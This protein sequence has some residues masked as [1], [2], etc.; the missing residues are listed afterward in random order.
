MPTSF[1]KYTETSIKAFDFNPKSQE[2][3][4]RKQ[5]IVKSIAEHYKNTP[6]SILFYGFSPL[7]MG[8]NCKNISVTAITPTIKNY[9]DTKGI[10]YTYIADDDL[11]Q[12]RKQFNWVVASDEYYTF[13]SSEQEQLDKITVTANLAKDLIV[14]TLRDYKIFS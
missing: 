6:S 3:V 5:E 8:C 2:V 10:K 13:A 11:G 12:Y 1:S 9:L 4:D 7:M 14:T